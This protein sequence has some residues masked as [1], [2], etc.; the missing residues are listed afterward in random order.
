M[1][2]FIWQSKSDRVKVLLD[3][4]NLIANS[5]EED[6]FNY[7]KDDIVYFHGKD[8]K[9]NDARGRALGEGDIDWVKFFYLYKKYLND[10]PFILE[11]V[12]LTN[13]EEIK[14]RAVDYYKKA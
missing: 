4:A 14:R 8:R 5:S 12:N 9:V 1:K 13:F 7:L 6:M 3:P 11:Y 10:K 2:D